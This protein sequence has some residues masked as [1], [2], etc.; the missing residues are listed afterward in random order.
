MVTLFARHGVK[1][2]DKWRSGYDGNAEMIKEYGVIEDTVHRAVDDNG[3]IVTHKLKDLETARA[4]LEMFGPDE[5]GEQL[6]EM[7]ALQS[8]TMWLGEDV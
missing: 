1:D 2:Y 4:F 7:G 6:Q 3:V 5:I 8:V